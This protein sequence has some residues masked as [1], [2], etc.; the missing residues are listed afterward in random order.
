VS[1][2]HLGLLVGFL[3]GFA[4]GVQLG[5]PAREVTVSPDDPRLLTLARSVAE[6]AHDGQVRKGSGE[7]YIV[8]PKRVAE[9]A[10]AVAGVRGAVVGYLHDVI[11][12]TTVDFRT[13]G[14]LFPWPIV[15][16]VRAVTRNAD[17]S[18]GYPLHPMPGNPLEP[19][20]VDESYREFIARTIREGSDVAL[21]VKLR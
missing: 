14:Q 17:R 21:Q 3:V 7:P 18:L 9:R 1:L 15:Q 20:V 13:L 8:H 6:M 16:D 5:A 12:D 11:E 2:Y 4:V 10:G 19:H